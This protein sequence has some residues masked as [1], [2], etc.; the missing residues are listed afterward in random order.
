ELADVL[1]VRSGLPLVPLPGLE[2][3][4]LVLHGQYESR[5]ILTAVGWLTKDARP[6]SREGVLRLKDQ[7]VE[8]MF[9]TL[10][11]SSGY[12]ETVNYHDY[13]ISPSLFHWQTQNSA[14]PE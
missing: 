13:A 7:R 12:H 4:S 5:E 6:Q 9:V 2:D 8:L 14:G 11:K 3:T 1:E 10:D